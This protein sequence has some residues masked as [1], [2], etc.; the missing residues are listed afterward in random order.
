MLVGGGGVGDCKDGVWRGIIGNVVGGEESKQ[1]RTA[2]AVEYKR[3]THTQTQTDRQ[4]FGVALQCG[5]GGVLKCRIIYKIC[6]IPT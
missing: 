6:R 2:R 3:Y 1:R 4:A 5:S